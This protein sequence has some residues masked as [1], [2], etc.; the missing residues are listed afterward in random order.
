LPPTSH[1]QTFNVSMLTV[2]NALGISHVP[3]AIA[4]SP[5]LDKGTAV[6]YLRPHDCYSNSIRTSGKPHHL[7]SC[8]KTHPQKHK[9]YSPFFHANRQNSKLD[10]NPNTKRSCLVLSFCCCYIL[11]ASPPE[12]GTQ[13]SLRGA[14]FSSRFGL[15]MMRALGLRNNRSLS[16]REGSRSHYPDQTDPF[17]L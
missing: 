11:D 2:H 4:P 9:S 15:R 7:S 16:G 8:P 13:R 10:G 6:G 3:N 1:L 17:A 14:C 5:Q 12:T